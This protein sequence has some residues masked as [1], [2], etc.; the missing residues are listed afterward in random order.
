[1]TQLDSITFAVG[2]LQT[3]DREAETKLMQL[4]EYLKQSE[5]ETIWLNEGES[6]RRLERMVVP[7]S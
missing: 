5:E 3:V 1:V 2:S 4:C 7:A 6:Y